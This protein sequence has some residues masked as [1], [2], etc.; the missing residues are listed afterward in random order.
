MW[1]PSLTRRITR[2]VSSLGK[3]RGRAPHDAKARACEADHSAGGKGIEGGTEG[4]NERPLLAANVGI[5][6]GACDNDA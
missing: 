1:C 2:F 4:R 5:E 6:D 3:A